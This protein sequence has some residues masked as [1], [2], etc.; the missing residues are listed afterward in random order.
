MRD[1][2]NAF[3]TVVGNLQPILA[4]VPTFIEQAAMS[5]DP[6]EEDVLMSEFDSVIDTPASQLAIEEMIVMDMDADLAEIQKPIAP[7]PFTPQNIEQLFTTSVT[8]KNC[9]VIFTPNQQKTWQLTYQGN[10][11]NITFYPQTFDET[12]SLRLISFGDSLF[13]ELL[14]LVIFKHSA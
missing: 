10:T 13:E 3:A 5:A 11:Y 9:N 7:S 2:I 1:H 14:E 6:E 12:P 8:L 4:Q